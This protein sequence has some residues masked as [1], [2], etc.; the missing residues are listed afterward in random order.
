MTNVFDRTHIHIFYSSD[1]L[2]IF[3]QLNDEPLSLKQIYAVIEHREQNLK[4]WKDLQAEVFGKDEKDEKA[5][6]MTNF[7]YEE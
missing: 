1:I 3:V 2:K 5:V 7:S 6:D 4:F